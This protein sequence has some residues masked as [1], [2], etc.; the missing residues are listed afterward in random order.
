MKEL[1]SPK[2]KLEASTQEMFRET[3][4]IG[5]KGQRRG[6]LAASVEI[7]ESRRSANRF[8]TSNECVANKKRSPTRVHPYAGLK[9]LS[10]RKYR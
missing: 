4:T 2:C 9:K 10:E 6:D 5:S 3:N 8:K 1:E 7:K